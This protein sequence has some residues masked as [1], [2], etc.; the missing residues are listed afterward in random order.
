MLKK[1]K[2]KSLIGYLIYDVGSQEKVANECDQEI[3]EAYDTLF[4]KLEDMYSEADRN[5]DKLAD[6]IH[7]FSMLHKDIYFEA[8]L[9]MGFQLYKNLEIGYAER[10]DFINTLVR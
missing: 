3:N 4:T 8:G 6:V 7:D 1:V 10:E 5:D 2:L 9:L